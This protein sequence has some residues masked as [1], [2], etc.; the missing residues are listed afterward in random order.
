[1]HRHELKQILIRPTC[2]PSACEAALAEA[3]VGCGGVAG[4][5]EAQV[6]AET[7][8][9]LSLF[10]KWIHER[11]PLLVLLTWTQRTTQKQLRLLQETLK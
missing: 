8:Q 4:V 1:M 10:R 9:I 2:R 5:P 11:L 3:A 7:L 6:A